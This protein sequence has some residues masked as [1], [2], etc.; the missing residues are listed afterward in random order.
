MEESKLD[1]E[2]RHINA[3]LQSLSV[4]M[5]KLSDFMV[6]QSAQSR[7]NE[8]KL[9]RIHQRIDNNEHR[10]NHIEQSLITL[11][12]EVI[13]QIEQDAAIKGEYWKIVAAIALPLAAGL[14]GLWVAL[15]E[16]VDKIVTAI[17]G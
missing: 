9:I 8:E 3:T 1:V 11:T 10:V 17:G 2:I 4:S 14:W 16:A 15:S 7:A 12:T 6:E 13:P 5:T